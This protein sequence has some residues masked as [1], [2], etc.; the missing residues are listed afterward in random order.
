MNQA[1]ISSLNSITFE[2][3]LHIL[4]VDTINNGIFYVHEPLTELSKR[5]EF[6]WKIDGHLMKLMRDSPDR[7]CFESKIFGETWRLCIIP[8]WIDENTA[9]SGTWFK[10]ILCTLP[11]P[12]RRMNIKRRIKCNELGLNEVHVGKFGWPNMS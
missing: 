8:N 7:A 10:L 2:I 3:K 5:N 6:E 11:K 1:D 12:T 9:V 4:R